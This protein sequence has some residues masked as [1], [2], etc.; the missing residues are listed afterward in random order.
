MRVLIDADLLL[1]LLL[2]RSEMVEK[3]NEIWKLAE[4]N[5]IQAF[6][7]DAGL[8]KIHFFCRNLSNEEFA[9]QILISIRKTVSNCQIN[10]NIIRQSFSSS[11]KDFESAIESICV[12]NTGLDGVVTH[13]LQNF[14]ES[15]SRVWSVD[16]FLEAFKNNDNNSAREKL[17]NLLVDNK[18]EDKYLENS[19]T[20]KSIDAKFCHDNLSNVN[21]QGAILEKEIQKEWGKQY[22][23]KIS[24][25]NDECRAKD[26]QCLFKFIIVPLI[27]CV[28][29]AVGSIG[30]ISTL[31]ANNYSLEFPLKIQRG[32]TR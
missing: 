30:V 5:K 8:G 26:N 22:Q 3:A 4:S 31:N 13:C 14:S 24:L 15:D 25:W 17:N 20:S 7:T 18:L 1:E 29:V 27:L 21:A 2:N 32:S 10:E 16:E 19:Q 12:K 11:L 23:S 9:D 6:V 28:G